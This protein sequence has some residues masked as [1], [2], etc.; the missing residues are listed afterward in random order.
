MPV[1]CEAWN[2]ENRPHFGNLDYQFAL[3]VARRCIVWCIYYERE[4]REAL[5]HNTVHVRFPSHFDSFIV[6]S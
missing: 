4:S 6:P 1:T 2:T 3:C 5:Y